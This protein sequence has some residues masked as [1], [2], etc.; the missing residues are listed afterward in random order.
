M[1][2]NAAVEQTERQVFVAEQPSLVACL[3]SHAE[4]TGAAQALD[5]VSHADSKILLAGVERE[6]YSDFLALLQRLASRFNGGNDKELDLSQAEL[7]VGVVGANGEDL[8]G[9]CQN[10]LG[11]EWGA[12]GPL[13]DPASKQAVESFGIETSLTQLILYGLGSNHGMHLRSGI[14]SVH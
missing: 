12:V 6:P 13:F 7:V 10:R 11:D 9:S 4:D 8:L 14:Q 5:P 2:S 3:S 1:V